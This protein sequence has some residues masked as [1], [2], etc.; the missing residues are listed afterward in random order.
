MTTAAAVLLIPNPL[1]ISYSDIYTYSFLSGFWKRLRPGVKAIQVSAILVAGDIPF[2]RG[3]TT[4]SMRYSVRP[5]LDVGRTD[6]FDEEKGDMRDRD[7]ERGRGGVQGR[8]SPNRGR[9]ASLQ[10]GGRTGNSVHRPSLRRAAVAFVRLERE[11][12]RERERET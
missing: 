11:R 12:E 9:R 7:R 10:A 1:S 5:E 2:I 4:S 8:E 6:V 3:F